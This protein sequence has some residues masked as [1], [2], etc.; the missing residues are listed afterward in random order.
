VCIRKCAPWVVECQ[1]LGQ[2]RSWKG[3]GFGKLH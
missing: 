2:W 1:K 3:Y